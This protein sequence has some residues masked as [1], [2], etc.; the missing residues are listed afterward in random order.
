MLTI[1]KNME[2]APYCGS[3]FGQD[4]EP[5]GTYVFEKKIDGKINKPW[6]EGKANI[7]NPLII[8]VNDDTLIS[9]KYE[10]SKKYKAKN[11]RLTEKLMNAG[12]DA[13]ITMNNG[14]SGEI[15]LFPNCNFILNGLNEFKIIIKQLL[16][17]KLNKFV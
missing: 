8:D 17:E 1:M 11:K 4:V 6:V 9:Y 10:L 5:T 3:K 14:S 2:K 16:K 7:K 12:Y 15:I 13:I